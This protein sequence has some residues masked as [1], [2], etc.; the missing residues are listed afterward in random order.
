M[1]I[2]LAVP[3]EAE[4]CWN[5]RN[6]S[7]REGCKPSY[8]AR[9]L[10]A[11]TPDAMPEHYREVIKENPF[12]VVEKP[13]VGLIATG[14]LDLAAASVEAIFTLPDYFGKGLAS[15]IIETIKDEAIKRGLK[16]LTL[17]A[18]PNAQTFYEK[19]GFVFIKEST[20]PSRLAQTDLRCMDMAIQL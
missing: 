11:W 20:S 19:H 2:R 13:G 17:S 7:I 16:Q 12:F 4:E 10:E 18:T 3:E 8:S 15:L 9:V 14:Y 5:I 6:L 1:K